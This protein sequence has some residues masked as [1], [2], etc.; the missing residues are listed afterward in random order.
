M[1]AKP[2]VAPS[3]LQERLRFEELLADLSSKFVNLAPAQVDHEIE[4]A[5][6]RV[7]ELV[8]ID[9]ATLWQWSS[10]NPDVITPTHFYPA[11]VGPEPAEPLHQEQY[12]WSVQQMLAGRMVV[13]SSMEEA[14]AEAAVDRE[15]ARLIGIKSNLCLPLAVGGGPPVGALAFNTLLGRA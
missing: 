3:D 15:S 9:S 1:S 7:C 11:P 2:A 12:P 6:C 4:D 5:L 13:V 14:P 10:E 8:G